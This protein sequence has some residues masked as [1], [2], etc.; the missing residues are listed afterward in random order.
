[1]IKIKGS[2]AK[3]KGI[4]IRL[5]FKKSFISILESKAIDITSVKYRMYAGQ[6]RG[7]VRLILIINARIIKTLTLASILWIKLFSGVNNSRNRVS[8]FH[9]LS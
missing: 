9:L 7:G 3:R 8:Y 6:A 5:R 4:A 1:L 2:A